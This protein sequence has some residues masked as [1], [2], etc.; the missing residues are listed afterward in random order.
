MSNS[1]TQEI[2]L[3]HCAETIKGGIATYLRDLLACQA[4]DMDP[5]RIAVVIPRSQV[6]DLPVPEG[7]RVYTF[8]DN[9]GRA[10]NAFRLGFLVARLARAHQVKIT[11]AHSTFA[12]ATVRPLLAMSGQ[13]QRII[14][15]PHGWAWDRQASAWA[16]KATQWVER[17]LSK[18]CAKVVCI[19][20]HELKAG[21]DAGVPASR[22]QLI[23]NGVL[24]QAPPAGGR[25][26]EWPEG[27][28]RLLF[29]GRFDRQKGVDLFC[30][31]MEQLGEEAFGML[32][33]GA[34]L[35]DA[36]QVS[37]PSNVKLL[38]WID[39]PRLQ[40]LLETADV[41]VVPS[42]WEGFGLIA[43]EAMRAG[44]PVIAARVGGL[45]E[46]VADQETGLL[47][48]PGDVNGIVAAVRRYSRHEWQQKGMAGKA[49]FERLF[50]MER[51]HRQL[52]DLY[53]QTSVGAALQQKTA[54]PIQFERR[55]LE[56]HLPEEPAQKTGTGN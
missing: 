20:E 16:K 23:V 35:E 26:P 43:A 40:S 2:D 41:L 8:N 30:A 10:T 45:P 38:G 12:G 6:E 51:V 7:V 39:T 48:E 47:F 34:V 50:T 56:S 13:Q 1:C 5:Q 3:L 14:Y 25:A 44:L 31:A 53:S 17:A 9:A 18:H 4:R 49:R 11:H 52:V 21:L 28:K 42:R 22:L 15:C 24:E 32:A 36:D 27:K 46:I 37:P 33:G 29:V 54:H 19:S 55:C